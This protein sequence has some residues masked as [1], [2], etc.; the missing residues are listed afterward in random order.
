MFK[1]GDRCKANGGELPEGAEYAKIHEFVNDKAVIVS[2]YKDG[3]ECFDFY[4]T[5]IDNLIKL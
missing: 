1:V 5:L 2:L 3:E 4:F